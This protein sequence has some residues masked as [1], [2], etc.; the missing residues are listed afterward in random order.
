MSSE[1]RD[2][3]Q[4]LLEKDPRR[5]ADWAAVTSHPFVEE[6]FRTNPPERVY[7]CLNFLSNLCVE[8]NCALQPNSSC[9]SPLTDPLTESRELAKEMQRQDKA[10]R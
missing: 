4:M 8:N 5:R 9:T 7:N 3:L 10:A 6:H 1:C 2:F